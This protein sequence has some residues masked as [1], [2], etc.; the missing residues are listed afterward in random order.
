MN[1][2]LDTIIY[3][4][5]GTVKSVAPRFIVSDSKNMNNESNAT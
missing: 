5:S 1:D 4:P 2:I 3:I